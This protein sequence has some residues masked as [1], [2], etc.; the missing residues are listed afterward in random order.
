MS[1]VL[2]EYGNLINDRDESPAVFNTVRNIPSSNS[3]IFR[4]THNSAEGARG[5]TGQRGAASIFSATRQLHRTVQAPFH[6][7]EERE[8][9][10]RKISEGY[11]VLAAWKRAG[12][13]M[14]ARWE[15]DVLEKIVAWKTARQPRSEFPILPPTPSFPAFPTIPTLPFAPKKCDVVAWNEEKRKTIYI[16]QKN[17]ERVL[18]SW[19]ANIVET[20][21][22]YESERRRR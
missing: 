17:K 12:D 16:W 13:A 15:R 7:N 6:A 2:D 22:R 3:M 8:I 1:Y 11:E 4:A 9:L 18:T 5:G 20:K 19:R 21:A 10:M 14:I